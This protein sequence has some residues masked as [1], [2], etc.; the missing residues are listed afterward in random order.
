MVDFEPLELSD[1][2]SYLEANDEFLSNVY[3]EDDQW[4]TA[5]QIGQCVSG[6]L[7][8]VQYTIGKLLL[9]TFIQRLITLLNFPILIK[10]ISCIFLGLIILPDWIQRGDL[11]VTV[12]AGIPVVA[13]FL[14]FTPLPCKGVS[15]M[16][17][18]ISS[19]ICVQY[20]IPAQDFLSIRGILMIFAMK[21]IS[22]AF[23]KGSNFSA[24]DVV[25]ILSYLFSPSTMVF[26]PFHTFDGYMKSF[27]GRTIKEELHSIFL[28][29]TLVGV[30]FCFLAY[31]SCL[32]I[33]VPEG[34]IL[35]DYVVAQSFRTSH[36][37]ICVLS[38]GL[39][40]LSGMRLSICSP[41]A[42]EVPRSLVEVVVAWNVPMHNF[43]HSYVYVQFTTLGTAAAILS[44]FAISSLLHGFN[45]QISAV[46]LSLG[47]ACYFENK[48][49]NRMSSCFS[50]CVRA[51][52]CRNCNHEMKSSCWQTMFLNALFFAAAVYQLVYLG[53][54][55]DGEGAEV[56]YEWS[57]TIAT[58]RRHGFLG[59]GI[60]AALAVL[61]LCF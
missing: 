29:A 15:A 40:L 28:S 10:H 35:T 17:A 37:F 16:L 12:T 22:L 5:Y 43:L 32:P 23:D 54:P 34:S 53:A 11:Q 18:C 20:L 33:I 24:C 7:S 27:N 46:L 6:C 59:H 52:P 36:Y 55:F 45:F 56:G 13:L 8:S 1:E 58:W 61:S 51:R 48:L 50:I 25:P 41:F 14:L 21:V 26:G 39:A 19:I 47:F 57:H 49:R 42:V 2:Y 4:S 31:S 60:T 9:V 3:F 30:A 44:S 38:Q